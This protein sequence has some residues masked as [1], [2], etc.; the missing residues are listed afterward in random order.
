M[1][2]LS[3]KN[4]KNVGKEYLKRNKRICKTQL[5]N[6]NKIIA[7]NQLAIPVLN[8]LQLWSGRLASK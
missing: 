2:E 3:I 1:Q 6:K 5:T 4:E 8:Y 7:I